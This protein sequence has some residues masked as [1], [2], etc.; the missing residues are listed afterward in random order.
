MGETSV[1]D[2]SL[3]YGLYK[4]QDKPKHL[5]KSHR[6]VTVSSPFRGIVASGARK[7]LVKT[8]EGSGH[9]SPEVFAYRA[10]LQVATVALVV[11]A[12]AEQ[13]LVLHGTVAL[14]DGDESDALFQ[15]PQ[16]GDIF[17][18]EEVCWHVGLWAVDS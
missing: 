16:R 8:M 10:E 3:Q 9:L 6:T 2:V 18:G 5:L 15:G 17:L 11:R 4:G 1:V 12:G 14:G 7:K 13:S